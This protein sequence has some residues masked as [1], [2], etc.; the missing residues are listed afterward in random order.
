MK[1]P[2]LAIALLLA[3]LSGVAQAAGVERADAGSIF[4]N[5][6][7]Q[8]KCPPVCDARGKTWDGNW[9]T[10]GAMRSTCDCKGDARSNER[11]NRK[12]DNWS[13]RSGSQ[14]VH[15]RFIVGDLDARNTCP[16]VCQA[17]GQMT[18]D[19]NWRSVGLKSSCDCNPAPRNDR[20]DRND[21]RRSDWNRRPPRSTPIQAGPIMG[22][23]DA[24]NTCPGVCRSQDRMAWDG[25]WRTTQFG[26]ASECDCAPETRSTRDDDRWER[27]RRPRITPVQAG[28]I[29]NDT[30]ARSTCPRVCDSNNRM[31]WD[32]NWRTTQMGRMSE[33][34]CKD[35]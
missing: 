14:T 11:D 10:E 18:W 12:A 17:N 25:N 6:D 30:H 35:R 28:P 20:N 4:N 33:C 23:S 9:R 21:D 19:G 24:R 8:R 2:L 13:R 16:N 27:N 26:R 1:K 7:A 32:G 31:I 22:D 5:M 34:D 15:S 3:I 29:G